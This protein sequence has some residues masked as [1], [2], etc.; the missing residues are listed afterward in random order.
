MLCNEVVAV[1]ISHAW[2]WRTESFLVEKLRK[3]V[4]EKVGNVD[5][6][7]EFEVVATGDAGTAREP[8]QPTTAAIPPNTAPGQK[9]T[10]PT[11]TSAGTA[12]ASIFNARPSAPS[13]FFSPS[14]AARSPPAAPPA[15]SKDELQAQLTLL[16]ARQ[17]SLRE[18]AGTVTQ[19]QREEVEHEV[20]MIDVQKA[21]LKHALKR[22]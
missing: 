15:R 18:S 12:H 8:A 19:R 16:R 5:E 6:P 4:D 20:R 7:S 11:S 10:A 9:T 14:V 17:Q 2:P 21:E 22:L 3:K 13:P 1:V